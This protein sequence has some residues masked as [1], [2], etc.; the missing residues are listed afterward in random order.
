MAK[1][2]LNL[3]SSNYCHTYM[4]SHLIDFYTSLSLSTHSIYSFVPTPPG[5][6]RWVGKQL[7]KPIT[8]PVCFA[9]NT[10]IAALKFFPERMGIL[11]HHPQSPNSP[12]SLWCGHAA[13][14]GTHAGVYSLPKTDDLEGARYSARALFII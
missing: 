7:L 6:V 10:A 14:A 9:H 11:Q 1:L 12:P 5:P 8:V 4:T 3:C 2:M 13:H